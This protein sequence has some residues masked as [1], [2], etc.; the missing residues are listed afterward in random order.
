MFKNM[1]RNL[2]NYIQL[3][4]SLSGLALF[5]SMFFASPEAA[6]SKFHTVITLDRTSYIT[7]ISVLGAYIALTFVL[8]SGLDKEEDVVLLNKVKLKH[9][10]QTRNIAIM[11]VIIS[12]LLFMLGK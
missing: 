5:A 2:L 12:Q 3:V 4:L 8:W 9:I 6:V 7:I 10:H 11:L 1:K